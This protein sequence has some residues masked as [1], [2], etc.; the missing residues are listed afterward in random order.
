MENSFH[1]NKTD[2]GIVNYIPNRMALMSFVQ[3]VEVYMPK[4]TNKFLTMKQGP[5]RIRFESWDECSRMQYDPDLKMTVYWD[6]NGVIRIDYDTGV[7][8]VYHPKPTIADILKRP[9]AGE[10]LRIHK[11]G[12]VE[13][14]YGGEY[15]YWGPDEEVEWN[16]KTITLCPSDSCPCQSCQY[17]SYSDDEDYVYEMYTCYCRYCQY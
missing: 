11:D 2:L 10:Y 5:P 6:A 17:D 4:S 1:S 3:T 8:E 15:Y 12:S 14:G 16:M 9:N 13:N 7:R